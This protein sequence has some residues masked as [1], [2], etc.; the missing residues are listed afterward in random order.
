MVTLSDIFFNKICLL[1]RH[2]Y[3]FPNTLNSKILN[4]LN[5][6][7]KIQLKLRYKNG[8]ALTKK[9]TRKELEKTKIRR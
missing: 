6:L 4:Q 2:C 8:K 1:Y 9:I 3:T 5:I 7:R